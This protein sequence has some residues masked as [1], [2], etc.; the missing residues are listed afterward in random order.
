MSNLVDAFKVQYPEDV[1]K[2]KQSNP[3]L[4]AFSG[5]EIERLWER[6]S[7]TYCAGFLIVSEESLANFNKWLDY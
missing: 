1:E 7:D 2:I 4:A 6:F 5:V 3:I